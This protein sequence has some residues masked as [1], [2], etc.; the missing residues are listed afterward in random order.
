VE[1]GDPVVG[2]FRYDTDGAT[3]RY[4]SDPTYARYEYSPAG[5][6]SLSIEI[7]GRRWSSGKTL[8]IEVENN[9]VFHVAGSERP[10]S[11]LLIQFLDAGSSF[12]GNKIAGEGSVAFEIAVISKPGQNRLEPNTLL[13]SDSLPTALSDI[14][15]SEANELG[16]YVLSDYPTYPPGRY[17]FFVNVD[18]ASVRFTQPAE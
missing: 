1:L 9:R 5:E 15:I 16:V 11:R 3:D 8:R 17:G 13:K 14:N 4:P 10:Q 2:H 7:R 18:P 6:N 12:P